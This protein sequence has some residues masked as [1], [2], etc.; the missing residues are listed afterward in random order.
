MYKKKL[1]LY[2]SLIAFIFTGCEN[3]I[4]IHYSFN[5]VTISRIDYDGRTDFRYGTTDSEN[6]SSLVV[7]EYYGFNNGMDIFMVFKEDRSVELIHYGGEYLKKI[8]NTKIIIPSYTS[9]KL[10]S[11]IDRYRKKGYGIVRLSNSLKLEK[12][13]PDN[14]SSKVIARYK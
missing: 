13:F 12:Q 7:A 6:D 4:T 5:G 11:V 14:L 10:M 9:D 8:G 2:L 1:L 3:N